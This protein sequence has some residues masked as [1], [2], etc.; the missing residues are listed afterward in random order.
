MHLLW[1]RRPLPGDCRNYPECEICGSYDHFTSGHNRVIQIRGGVLAESSQSSESSIG[2]SCTT[3][4]SSVHSTADHNDFEHF[5]RGEKLQ[6][7]KAKEPTKKWVHKIRFLV[8]NFYLRFIMDDPNITMEEYIRLEE[9]KAQR[10]G[11]TFSWQ[12]ASFGKVKYYE[13]E[14]DCFTNFETKFPAIVFDDTLTS[15]A[16][17]SCEPTVSPLNENEIDFRISF[18]ESDDEDYMRHIREP[19][20]Y[21][22]NRC[23]RGMDGVKSSLPKYVEQPSLRK[24][25]HLLHMDLSRPISPMSINHEK[26]TLVIVDEYSRMVENQ[27]DVKVKQIK[28]DNGTAFRNIELGSFCDKKGI[29]Q[30]FSSSYT[31]EQ[32][33]VAEMKNRTLI[34]AARTVL[35][36]LVLSKHF[37]TEAVRISCYTQNRSIIVKRHD[38]TPYEIFRE[39]IPDISYFHVFGCPM[40]IYNYKDH[41]GKFD[42]KADDRVLKPSEVIATNEQDNPQTEDVK[43]PPDPPNTKETQEQNVQN[44]QINHQLTKETSGINTKILVPI[45]ESLAPEVSQSHDTNQA[46][47]RMF[48]KSMAAK[49]IATSAS[50]CLFADFL[51]EIELKKMYAALKHPEWVDAM[52]EENKKDEYGI[53]TKNKARL[54]AQDFSQEEGIDYDETFVPVERMEAIRIFLA[55]ATYMNFIVFQMDIKSAFLNGKAKEEVYVKQPHGF[56]SSEFPDYVCKLNKALYE[57]KQA[58]RECMMGELTYFLGLQIKQDDKGISICQERS[59]L[60]GKLV[61]E[62]LYRG[63]IGSLMYLKGTPSPGLYYLNCSGFDLKGYS[64]SDYAGCNMDRKSTSGA[65]QILKGK[66]VCWRAKKQQLVAMS[67]AK[68]KYVAVAGDHILKGDIELHFIPTDYQL[69]DIF[70]KPLDE[71]TFTRLKAELGMLNID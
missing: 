17:L 42:A 15:D 45:T 55:F 28:T 35:N 61:N 43:G 10:H 2:V 49:L 18:D 8:C 12:T 36:G 1:I 62:T 22:D 52:Q 60:A 58:P 50:E 20:W 33:G 32:N 19:I 34:E 40:F 14:D 47:T 29:S 48:T 51:S 9:E 16:A 46:S 67:S 68:A 70:I 63:M 54:V 65:C 31:P 44:E 37:W 26:Y 69:A 4:G 3:C 7:T 41:I 30:N 5:K 56:K 59:D 38:M 24:C 57:L 53:V 13:D 25:L 6:A 39:R 66:L 11:R 23:S 21:L 71:P 64:D 27:N